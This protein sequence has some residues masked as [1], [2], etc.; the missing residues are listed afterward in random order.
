MVPLKALKSRRLTANLLKML[1]WMKIIATRS[2]RCVVVL[3]E[4]IRITAPGNSVTKVGHCRVGMISEFSGFQCIVEPS[5]TGG[6]TLRA[7]HQAWG[8]PLGRSLEGTKCTVWVCSHT[9]PLSLREGRSVPSVKSSWC[10]ESTNRLRATSD[11]SLTASKRLL[12]GQI[13]WNLSRL[14]PLWI[15]CRRKSIRSQIQIFRDVPNLSMN[16]P[17]I[18]T[19]RQLGCFTS[20]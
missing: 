5:S 10:K 8:R 11:S 2:L 3:R 19:A 13:V 12:F 20:S 16:T 6:G 14:K 15:C 18:T 4:W 9:Y 1:S 17:F 7:A